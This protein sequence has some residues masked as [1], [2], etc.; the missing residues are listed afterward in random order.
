MSRKRRNQEQREAFEE[1]Q[2]RKKRKLEIERERQDLDGDA[3]TR[4]RG[5]KGNGNRKNVRRRGRAKPHKVGLSLVVIQAIVSMIFVGML[6]II[7]IIP[8]KYMAVIVIILLL[9]FG[10]TLF[11]QLNRRKKAIGGKILSGILIVVIS[12]STFYIGKANGALEK[13]SGGNYKIDNMV[14]AVLKDD[15]AKDIEDTKNY[16]FGVQYKMGRSDMEAAVQ[17]VSEEL[18]TDIDVVEYED[19]QKQA[20]ALH[21]KKVD[22]IIYNEGY[23]DNI[24]ESFAGYKKSVRIIYE[25][26]IK[27]ELASTSVDASIQEPFSVYISGID[28]YGEIQQTSR[29]DVNIIATVNPKTHQI[30]LVTTPRD[31]YVPIPGVSGGEGDKLTH[32]GT[33][34]VD[35]SMATLEDLY[36]TEIPFFA[37]IN[38]TS[39]ID[40]VDHLGGVDV[41]SEYAFTTSK[42]SE[43]VMD[44]Q[45]GINH[46]DGEEALAFSR[47][48]ENVPGGD[49]QRGKNQ[50]AVITAMIKKMISPQMLMKANSI[51]DDVSGN[52]ET[53]MS[54][55]QI[56]SL[57]KTQLN[58]GGS[59]NIYSVAAEGTGGKDIC[60]SA[61]SSGPLY[62][63]Y[64]DEESVANIQDLINRVEAGEVIE[65]SE[66]AK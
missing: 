17:M 65:G 55:E 46:F 32:A 38:F 22:A 21:D 12:F 8:L 6:Q 59:W 47:E 49:N 44:V 60:Y 2:Q 26:K 24:S 58:R 27:K 40:I 66:V 30:L 19:L 3:R 33:Y 36:E 35:V 13:I 9:L 45:Q 31:Y 62:V 48:R 42:N 15:P 61:A 34:G 54:Q 50:Q 1:L 37:R 51:I 14:V 43:H 18:G 29:S 39:L 5:R 11:T 16:T 53:N 23:T 28:V 25:H 64:P 52:V 57:I 41:Y 7:G 10:L 4:T 20:E 56:Q 63:T